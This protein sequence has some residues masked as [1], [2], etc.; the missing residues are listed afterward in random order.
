MV[1][2]GVPTLP[3]GKPCGAASSPVAV[4]AWIICSSSFF[5]SCS[6]LIFSADGT[7]ESTSEEG[8]IEAENGDE[9]DN[10]DED[11]DVEGGDEFN[12]GSADADEPEEKEEEE[13]E[14]KCGLERGGRRNRSRNDKVGED[15]SD[16][17][18]DA[19]EG[20]LNEGEGDDVNVDVDK[21]EE[22]VIN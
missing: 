8:K 21:D 15:E 4:A 19:N 11:K 17:A 2:V 20:V 9:A 1:C 5:L 6:S 10:D 3:C 18:E 14:E 13:E 22:A 12:K 7:W 16:D